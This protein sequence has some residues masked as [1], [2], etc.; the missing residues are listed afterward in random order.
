[1]VTL[2]FLLE[3]CRENR[4][5]LHTLKKFDTL[6]QPSGR[7]ESTI[8]FLVESIKMR[9]LFS[10]KIEFILFR[11]KLKELKRILLL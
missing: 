9:C 1:M 11:T 8:C 6:I 5:F 2:K 4:Y 3:L 7:S 10:L